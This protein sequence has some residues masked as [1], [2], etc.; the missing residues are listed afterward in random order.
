MQKTAEKMVACFKAGFDQVENPS[1]AIPDDATLNKCALDLLVQELGDAYL[2]NEAMRIERDHFEEEFCDRAELIKYVD[3]PVA[4]ED[5]MF[6][7]DAG[8]DFARDTYEDLKKCMEDIL[9]SAYREWIVDHAD[10]NDA[11]EA[12]KSNY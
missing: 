7:S 5:L 10:L 12:K 1:V 3:A 8:F 9:L 6:D 11:Y 4:P 2:R